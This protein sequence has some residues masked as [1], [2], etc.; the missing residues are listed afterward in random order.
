MEIYILIAVIVV[1]FIWL[2][3]TY[4]RFISLRRFKD[5]AWS[6]IA[7]Q[8]KRRHDLLPNLLSLVKQYAQHEKDLLETISSHR[9]ELVGNPGQIAENERK[10]SGAL[11]RVFALAESY[12]E[13][14]ANENY[15]A[16]HQSLNEI[17]EQIQM[18]RRYFNGTV[19]DFNILVESFPSL[20]L[21][22]LFNFKTEVFFEL[23]NPEDA[24]VPRME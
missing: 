5:E 10:Y 24:Q 15:L 8:L 14:K 16:L 9:H 17:E 13:L 3:L 18:T 22:K 23:D 4:N 11:N 7:V 1:A 21:A 19:R 2:I 12:P 20:I 6:G